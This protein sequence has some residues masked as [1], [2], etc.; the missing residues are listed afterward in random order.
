MRGLADWEKKTCQVLAAERRCIMDI[1]EKCEKRA[2]RLCLATAGIVLAYNGV[3]DGSGTPYYWTGGSAGANTA[4]NFAGNWSTSDGQ[5]SS[6]G[7]LPSSGANIAEIDSTATGGTVKP[8]LGLDASFSIN[9]VVVGGSITTPDE[10]LDDTTLNTNT[11]GYTLT[12]TGD[13][14][15][16]DDLITNNDSN[17]SIFDIRGYESATVNT[18]DMAVSITGSG[19]ID[20]VNSN[21]TIRID[22]NITAASAITLN[23]VGSGTLILI[24][25]NSFATGSILNINSGTVVIDSTV[26]LSSAGSLTTNIGAG[27]LSWQNAITDP[28]ASRKF[29]VTSASSGID[30]GA[31]SNIDMLGAIGGTGGLTKTSAGTL[32]L[33]GANA[34]PGATNVYGG[35]LLLAPLS[36]TSTGAVTVG[37]GGSNS[38]T[39]GG[40]GTV[41]GNITVNSNGTLAPGTYAYNSG[42]PTYTY[43]TLTAS[44]SLTINAGANMIEKLASSA[45]YD[46]ITL[47]NA[48]SLNLNG[49]SSAPITLNLV[50]VSGFEPQLTDVYDLITVPATETVNV[51]PNANLV[52]SVFAV[53]LAPFYTT[54]SSGAVIEYVPDATGAD[55]A[56]EIELTDVAPEPTGATLAMVIAAGSLLRRRRR[57]PNA[58]R[59]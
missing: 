12:L 48:G 33:S 34:Y 32:V 54:G 23:K 41:G 10:Y 4:W 45:H 13:G 38:G 18:V 27:V 3:S 8:I 59:A 29:N 44:G 1:R 2:V 51:T 6:T 22:P 43:G 50:S 9:S 20:P 55:T 58:P 30:V 39:L 49:T 57:K 37:D 46:S 35:Q 24:G 28:S 31:S 56:G 52:G 42:N 11:T 15:S 47:S 16:S 17:T 25:N 36:S 14:S 19:N 40:N 26:Q 7:Q 21:D 5:Y 53:N